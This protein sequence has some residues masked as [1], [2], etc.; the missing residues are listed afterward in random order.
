MPVWMFDSREPEPLPAGHAIRVEAGYQSSGDEML[1][2]LESLV[3]A[4]GADAI[5]ALVIG[6]WGGMYGQSSEVVVDWLVT[7]AGRL[8][9]LTALYRGDVSYE[10]CE[11]S[12]ILQ[13]DVAPWPT[14]C[15]ASPC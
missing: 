10:Q 3:S 14:T 1:A 11:I 15:P 5:Q 2:E 4:P 13:S 6:D 8:P 7:N 12:W 9:G